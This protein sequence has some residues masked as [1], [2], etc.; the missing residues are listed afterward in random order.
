MSLRQRQ[1]TKTLRDENVVFYRPFEMICVCPLYEKIERRIIGKFPKV[2]AEASYII[3]Q[4][5][6]FSEL[7]ATK[8]DAFQLGPDGC[9]KRGMPC[10]IKHLRLT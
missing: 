6:N 1:L 8:A 9:F 3:N 4:D 7:V 5:D 10:R 2:G